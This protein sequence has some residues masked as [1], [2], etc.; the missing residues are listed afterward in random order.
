VA[1]L[2]I[3]LAILVAAL[4]CVYA[5]ERIWFHQR[6]A[7][8]ALITLWVSDVIGGG[9]VLL[10]VIALLVPVSCVYLVQ[11]MIFGRQRA[12][13]MQ[14]AIFLQKIGSTLSTVFPAR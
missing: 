7:R 2:S 1:Q 12:E 3:A 11:K 13:A 5:I 6:R 10:V 9:L 14:P 4:V 8:A